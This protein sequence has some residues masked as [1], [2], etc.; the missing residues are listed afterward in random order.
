M[1]LGDAAYD[2][3]PRRHRPGPGG[4]VA[5]LA[6]RGRLG[7]IA[8][9]AAIA[10]FGFASFPAPGW[11][12]DS[13]SCSCCDAR[14]WYG[15]LHGR[16]RFGRVCSVV[17]GGRRWWRRPVPE[18]LVGDWDAVVAF[19]SVAWAV[20]ALIRYPVTRAH[21]AEER[22]ARLEHEQA[23]AARLAVAEE[24]RADRPRAARRRRAHGVSVMAVQAGGA[25]RLLDARP[26]Q[27]D[28]TR[29]ARSRRPAARRWPR[30]AGCS[31]CCATTATTRRL[32]AA[33]G[34]RARSTRWSHGP[35]RRAA[36]RPRR[37]RATPARC[38]RAS[39]CAAYRIVQEA[40]TNALKHAGPTHAPWCRR[41]RRRR[42]RAR[43][44]RRRRGG[45]RRRRRRAR[46]G[47]HARAR[48]AVRRRARRRARAD[49]GF[50]VA[51][52]SR[53]GRRMSDPRPDRRRPGAGPRRLPHDPRG[54]A[55]HRGR[56]RGRATAT[57]RSR[58]RAELGPTSC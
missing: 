29:S 32:R 44:R 19:M 11:L 56:R 53:S 17:V 22:A 40:L 33:A 1:T 5:L 52:R 58:W 15:R 38:R 12:I 35:R 9:L 14:L 47:R 6:L 39:T 43:G 23:E 24:R 49:G 31:A 28:A 18:A 51:P 55:R 25:R 10:L 57:R 26:E 21:S 20:G 45:E 8:P 27:R 54:R 3:G 2:R 41:L 46:A 4:V 7:V 13:R 37:S 34:P 30:C 48:R 16:H 50:V 36:G 42:A